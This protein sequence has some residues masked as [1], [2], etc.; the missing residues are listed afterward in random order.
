MMAMHRAQIAF[1]ALLLAGLAFL[2][3]NPAF[4][5]W[6]WPVGGLWAAAAW[7]AIGLSLWSALWLVALGLVGDVL[8][9]APLGAWPLAFLAAYGAGLAA[10]R[11]FAPEDADRAQLNQRLAAEGVAL[12]LG[13]ALAVAALA[14][15]GGVSGRSGFASDAVI[16][17]ILLTAA[18]YPIA[19]FFLIPSQWRGRL[20]PGGGRR[21]NLRWRR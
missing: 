13:G 11:L 15:A 4:S 10:W 2:K 18:L 17:D 20:L 1:A 7:A 12:V 8:T 3:V 9:E 5:G 19:R 16:D 14:L 6:W 21:A